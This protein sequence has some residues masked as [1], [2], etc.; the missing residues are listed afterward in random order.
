LI[1]PADK[2]SHVALVTTATDMKLYLN[3]VAKVN[4]A[5]PVL[6]NLPNRQ[7]YVGID[8]GNTSRNFKGAIDEVVF[9]NRSLTQNEVREQMHLTKI[10]TND[11]AMKGYFQFNESAGPVYNQVNYNSAGLVGGAT[12]VTSTA[13][14]GTGT[15]ERQTVTTSGVKNFSTTGV[16]LQFPSSGT[17]PNGELCVTRL[18]NTPDQLPNASPSV[19]NYWIVN[20]YGTNATFAPLSN[21]TLTGYDNISAT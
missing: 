12:R 10:P 2:W 18:T 16:S 6:V 1:V 8:R 17:L 20:N 14:V 3:G 9:Y 15:S 11:V 4:T 19:T 5:D 21:I 7:W 13:P